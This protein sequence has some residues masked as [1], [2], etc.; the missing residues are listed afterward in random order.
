MNEVKKP[1]RGRV[2]AV[3]IAV[4]L[5][6]GSAFALTPSIQEVM[7][8]DPYGIMPLMLDDASSA[9]TAFISSKVYYG[10][11]TK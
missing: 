3:L 4:C 1:V 2:I 7:M 6:V 8:P 9:R 5:L 11:I 10:N